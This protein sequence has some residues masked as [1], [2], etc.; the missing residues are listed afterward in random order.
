MHSVI[1]KPSVLVINNERN[2]NKTQSKQSYSNKQ[3]LIVEEIKTGYLSRITL[4][5]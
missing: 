3:I 1:K 5:H 4:K 2:N